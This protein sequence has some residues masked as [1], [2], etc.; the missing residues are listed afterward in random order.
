MTFIL[1]LSRCTCFLYQ[2]RYFAFPC[3]YR[4]NPQ[5]LLIFKSIT[6]LF[7]WLRYV[8]PNVL[9]FIFPPVSFKVKVQGRFELVTYDVLIVPHT[10]YENVCYCLATFVHN[11]AIDKRAAPCY[12]T[13]RRSD[14]HYRRH[15]HEIDDCGVSIP[16]ETINNYDQ[17][18]SIS[19]LFSVVSQL[20]WW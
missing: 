8:G 5:P 19:M 11:V 10:K 14:F 18:N 17:T 3:V 7:S 1:S 2:F 9:T 16:E 4:P 13:W 15:H 6:V 12:L 20:L